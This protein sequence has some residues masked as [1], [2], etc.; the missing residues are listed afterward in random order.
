ML[1]AILK[2]L[3]PT[4]LRTIIKYVT[5]EN[6]LDVAVKEINEKIKVL[7]EHSHPKRKLI[8][9]HKKKCRLVE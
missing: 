3:T 4:I 8:C 1:P 6:E 9:K 2:L 5:E 7:E